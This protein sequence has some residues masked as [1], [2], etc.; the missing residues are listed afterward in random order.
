MP[1][2]RLTVA[3][4]KQRILSEGYLPFPGDSG[5]WDGMSALYYPTEPFA[6]LLGARVLTKHG[7]SYRTWSRVFLDSPM[8]RKAMRELIAEGHL[9]P[10]LTRL[11]EWLP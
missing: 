10:V 8:L 6:D 4:Y 3:Q 11:W 1:R 5:K 2:K 7:F 9:G